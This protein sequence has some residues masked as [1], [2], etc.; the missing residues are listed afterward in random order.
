MEFD[1]A[2]PILVFQSDHFQNAN[3][4]ARGQTQIAREQIQK[5]NTGHVGK[6]V[7]KNVVRVKKGNQGNKEKKLDK[8]F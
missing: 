8:I 4:N 6:N 2:E 5:R 1:V 3:S 7:T